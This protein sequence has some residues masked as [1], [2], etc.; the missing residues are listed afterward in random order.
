[1]GES[2]VEKTRSAGEKSGLEEIGIDVNF[3]EIP[4]GE[5]D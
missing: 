3:R 2:G 4:P 5:R 1:M